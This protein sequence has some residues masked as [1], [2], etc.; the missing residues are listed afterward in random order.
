MRTLD[1]IIPPSRRKEIESINASVPPSNQGSP[2]LP[3]KASQFPYITMLII[4][5][6]LGVAIGALFYFSSAKVEITPN[7][8]SVAVKNSFVASQNGVDVPYEIITAQKIASQ[9]A[10]S[11]GT[12][13]ASSSATGIITI[14][15]T[16]TKPQQLVEKTRFATSAGLI[17][18]T[19]TAVTI[20]GGT[21]AKP[22]SITAKVYSSQGG[23]AYNIPPTSF[24]VPGFAGTAK[25]SQV[26]A[27]STTA[28]TGGASG[29]VP[30]ID[31]TLETE[32]ENALITALAPDLIESIQAKIPSGYLLLPGSATTTYEK[33]APVPSQTTGQVT[34]KEQG[35]ITA[36]VFPSSALAKA[37]ATSITGLGYQGE[38]VSLISTSGLQLTMENGFPETNGVSFPF[39]LTGTAPLVYVVDP[40]R[41]SAAVAGK[42]RSAAEVALTNYPEVKGAIIILRPFWKQAFPQDPAKI[43]VSVKNP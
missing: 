6:V 31:A 38:P 40:T 33:L 26:Y 7:T 41:I 8:V 18:Y 42:T 24:T 4:V 20:P 29:N 11:S 16:Q 1:D 37:I 12:Q 10:K 27:R 32:I 19:Y 25:A 21:S 5:L 28:M 17:F 15:N 13:I 23:D 30:V 14:Y 3:E 36:V 34:V 9:S 22:G 43:S 39:T 2:R 35:T